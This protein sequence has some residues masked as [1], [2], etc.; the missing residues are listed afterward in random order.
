MSELLEVFEEP[1]AIEQEV[2]EVE[3]E[4]EEVAGESEAEQVEDKPKEPDKSEP[5]ADEEETERESW[6]IAAVKDE[7]QKR[8]EAVKRAEELERRIQEL[9]SKPEDKAERPDIFD[10]QEGYANSIEQKVNS[11]LAEARFQM[12]VDMMQSIHD[13]FEEVSQVF[14]EAAKEYPYLKVE[15]QKAANPAKYVYEQGKKYQQFQQLQDVSGIEA[16]IRAELEAKIRAELEAKQKE[17][18]EPGPTPSLAK[19]RGV[20]G[21]TEKL[22]ENPIDLF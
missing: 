18:D 13:D 12:S 6:T 11:R 16:K 10:D 21:E 9:E 7:R 17:E 15:A 2:Q 14:M 5:T 3:T 22:P 19:V 1:Q 20:S 4:Q 8:Q